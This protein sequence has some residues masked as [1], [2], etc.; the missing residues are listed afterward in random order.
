MNPETNEVSIMEPEPKQSILNIDEVKEDKPADSNNES[1]DSS[2]SETKR[3][4][5]I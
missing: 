2:S 5:N 4:I 1:K 3:I